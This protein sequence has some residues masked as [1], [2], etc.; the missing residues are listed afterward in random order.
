MKLAGI[1]IYL[2]SILIKLLN[3]NLYTQLFVD[4]YSG[5]LLP[6]SLNA[7]TYAYVNILYLPSG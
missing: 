7:S 3:V 4:D 6:D 2:K 5:D 1:S